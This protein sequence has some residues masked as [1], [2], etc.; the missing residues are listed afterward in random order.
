M[1]LSPEQRSMRA[2][3]AALTRWSQ[4]DPAAQSTAGQ[5]GLRAKFVREVT[6]AAA[7]RGEKPTDAELHRRAEAAYR[8]HMVRIRLARSRRASDREATPA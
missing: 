7:A 2:R 3:I 5:A 1:P 8:A 6:A 4:E